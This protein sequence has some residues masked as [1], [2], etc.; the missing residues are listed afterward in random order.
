M[1]MG[2]QVPPKTSHYPYF[3]DIFLEPSFVPQ[4]STF[5][6]LPFPSSYVTS[7]FSFSHH[8]GER[9]GHW[10]DPTSGHG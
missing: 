7:F 8:Q 4:I 10:I 1:R 5:R 3:Y 9:I 6:R 2:I